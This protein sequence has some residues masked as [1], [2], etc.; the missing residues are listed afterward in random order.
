MPCD[1]GS[2]GISLVG[3]QY[4]RALRLVVVWGGEFGGFSGGLSFRFPERMRGEA[5]RRRALALHIEDRVRSLTPH[6]VSRGLLKVFTKH[7]TR[8]DS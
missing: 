6:G 5:G 2:T 1:L 4:G 8:N 7:R 3:L